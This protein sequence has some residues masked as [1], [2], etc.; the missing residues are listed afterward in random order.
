S[1]W[2]A[3][4]AAALVTAVVM[5]LIFRWTT[6][7][8]RTRR[9]KDRLTARVLELV[10]FRHDAVVNFTALYRILAANAGYLQTVLAPL[11]LGLAPGLLILFQLSCWFAWRPLAV[12]ETAAVEV[13]LRDGFP[14]FERGVELSSAENAL[15]ETA[16]ARSLRPPAVAWRV[17]ADR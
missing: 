1:P 17:R 13:R 15:V 8:R 9:A 11:A 2:P 5:L 16:G 4:S 6:R 12:G 14:V 10:L 3:L 7:P